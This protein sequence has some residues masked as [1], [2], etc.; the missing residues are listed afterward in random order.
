MLDTTISKSLPYWLVNVPE[1][2][3]P[4]SCPDFLINANVKDRGILST[5]DSDY[6]RQTWPEVQQIISEHFWLPRAIQCLIL[7]EANRIDLFQRVPS[8]LRR[9]MGYNA[10]LKREYGSVMNFVVKERLQ[11]S[12]LR[13]KATAPF[14]DPGRAGCPY[15]WDRK[16]FIKTRI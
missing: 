10:K 8:D 9:Y 2:Q 6:H 11:W 1:D 14:S 12:D 3:W 4:E 5:P 15:F 13:P 16:S 7:E